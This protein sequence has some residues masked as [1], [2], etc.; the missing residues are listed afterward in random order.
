MEKYALLLGYFNKQVPLITKLANEVISLDLTVW[1]NRYVFALKTQQ[2]FT[3]LEDLF[4]Q[5]AK[6]FENHI[7]DLG[8]YHREL[9]IRMNIDVPNIRPALLTQQSFLFLDKIR[10]FRHFIR[11]AYDCE[12]EEKQLTL[13]QS[14]IKTELEPLL[15]D[16][17]RFNLYL[18]RLG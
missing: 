4:K 7:E 12:L 11:H 15:I 10:A 1:E 16:L 6:S 8:S 9:L 3:A 5:V 18:Q 14:L 13:L 17:Q 2:F